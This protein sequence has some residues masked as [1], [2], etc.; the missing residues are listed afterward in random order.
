MKLNVH[1]YLMRLISF[2]M[3]MPFY[4]VRHV[5]RI[6]KKK[7]PADFTFYPNYG[8]ERESFSLMIEMYP[9]ENQTIR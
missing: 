9:H 8:V 1:K 3:V 6:G 2:V 5:F 4:Q 7:A